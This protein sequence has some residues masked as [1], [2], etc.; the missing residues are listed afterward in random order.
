MNIIQNMLFENKK[1]STFYLLT[2]LWHAYYVCLPNKDTHVK[3]TG[4]K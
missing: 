2:F 1:P 3:K 4:N